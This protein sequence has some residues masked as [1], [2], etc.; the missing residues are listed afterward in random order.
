[1]RAFARPTVL[2]SKCLGFEPCRPTGHVTRS[3]EIDRLLPHVDAVT[4][5]PEMELGLPAPRDPMRVVW[6][7]GTPRW[8]QKDTQED[9]T[10]RLRALSA[11][12]LD[13]LPR[14]D[15][16]ILKSRS[17][18]CGLKNVLVH[19]G[20][21]AFQATARV[22]GVFGEALLARYPHVPMEE[23]DRLSQPK[24]QE[25]FYTWLFATADLHRVEDTG[26]IHELIEFHSRNKYQLM[27]LS[28][29]AQKEL[30][31]V[32]ANHDKAPV[33][34]VFARYKA[35]F[36]AAFASPP[37]VSTLTNALS[38]CAGYFTKMVSQRDRNYMHRNLEEFRHQE[39][40]LS[41]PLTLLRKWTLRFKEPYLMQQT[42]FWP[43]PEELV[44]VI[45]L[46]RGYFS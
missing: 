30:G 17:A 6:M 35:G 23:D 26:S 44:T 12:V 39:V 8:I 40:P 18:T 15:G 36:H 46:P 21:G 28:P 31:S 5:C 25:H 9:F 37:R 1:M 38:H 2:I 4:V 29:R 20:E 24:S 45:E 7:N 13:S 22:T 33:P 10:D 43:Y 34:E 32:V 19:P 16:A 42:F 41:T 14:L 11:S 3:P 27:A